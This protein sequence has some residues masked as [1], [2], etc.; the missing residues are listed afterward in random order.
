MPRDDRRVLHRRRVSAG[1]AAR[2]WLGD[3]LVYDSAA[4]KPVPVRLAATQFTDLK[5]EFSHR[6]GPARINVKWGTDRLVHAQ[7]SEHLPPPGDAANL[8]GEGGRRRSTAHRRAQGAQRGDQALRRGDRRQ[9]VRLLF[10]CRGAGHATVRPCSSARPAT[11][12][13]TRW[14]CSRGRRS[15]SADLVVE[16]SPAN[17][18]SAPAGRPT[19]RSP[20]GSPGARAE[21]VKLTPPAGFDASRCQVKINGRGRAAHV[22]RRR[23]PLSTSQITQADGCKSYTISTKQRTVNEPEVL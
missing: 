15:A 14:R 12:A 7:P 18:A 5:V 11:P 10:R 1:D 23:N 9:G 4:G 6:S 13:R 22:G 16:R 2:I 21:R 8:P 17:S 19:A 20:A 3:Q